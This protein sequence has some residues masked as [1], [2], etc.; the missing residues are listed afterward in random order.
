LDAQGLKMSKSRGNVVDPWTMIHRFGADVVRLYLLASSQVWLPKPFDPEAI[1]EVAGGFLNTLKNTYSFLA[2]YAG[3]PA[4]NGASAPAADTDPTAA[5]L[6]RWIRSR[7][8]ATVNAVHQAWSDYDATTG[9]RALIDFVVDDLS[10]WYVRQSRARFWA[11]DREADPAAVATLRDCLVVSAQL[12]APA[13][14]FVSDW[15]HRALTG[16]SVHLSILPAALPGADPELDLAMSAVRRLASLGRSAREAGNLRVRQTLDAMR[17]AVPGGAQNGR[18]PE[19]L[20]LLAQEVNVRRV[21]VVSSDEELVR[22]RPKPNFRSLGKR[23]GKR[24]PEVAAATATLSADDLRRLE[25]GTPVVLGVNGD[26]VDLLPDDVTVE[27]EVASDWLVQSTGGF[28][29][30]VDPHLTPELVQDGLAREVVNRV[31]RLRK[32]AGYEYTTRIVVA[33]DGAA[34][35]LDAVRRRTDFIEHETLARQLRIAGGLDRADAGETVEI[36]GRHVTI[37]VARWLTG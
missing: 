8:A 37:A 18:F 15:L 32:E 21:D 33:I 20:G 25:A 29:V 19:L 17:V 5:L 12:L 16:A 7:L 2:L 13:A 14:P 31:Q 34:D 1:P 23:F 26:R 3:A 36:D 27:R 10:N 11:P 35:V 6:D 4:A 9:I 24:T 30:A 28:V 22:L